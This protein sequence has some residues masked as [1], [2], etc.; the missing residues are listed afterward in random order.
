MSQLEN[1]VKVVRDEA[2][3]VCSGQD[4]LRAV[5]VIEAIQASIKTS[6]PVSIPNQA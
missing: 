2:E 4:G 5:A 3:P 6:Q 1:V